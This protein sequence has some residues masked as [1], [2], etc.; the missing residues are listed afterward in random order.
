[1]AVQI[2][3]HCICLFFCNPVT[4]AISMLPNG[5]KSLSDSTIGFKHQLCIFRKSRCNP[6]FQFLLSFHQKPAR[7]LPPRLLIITNRTR[8]ACSNRLLIRFRLSFPALPFDAHPFVE[9]KTTIKL[10]LNQMHLQPFL[11]LLY[12]LYESI[13]V[14]SCLNI[15]SRCQLLIIPPDLNIF[16][17]C[18]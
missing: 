14:T 4:T 16:P 11:Q 7:V 1:M 17:K 2:L 18:T 10:I 5:S 6:F 15:L 3:L 8:Q 13:S 12:Q 9:R